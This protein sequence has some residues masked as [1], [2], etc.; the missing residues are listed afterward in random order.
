MKPPLVVFDCDGTLVDGQHSILSTMKQVFSANALAMPS[1]KEMRSTIGLS[2]VTAMATLHPD[3]DSGFHFD[4]SEQYK[5]VFGQYRMSPEFLHEPLYEGILQVLHDLEDAGYLLA[6]ATGKSMRGLMRVLGHHGLIDKFI[7]LQTAD[8]HPS[9]PHPSM[10]HSCIADAGSHAGQ[11]LV[12]G[13]TSYDMEMARAAKTTA[14]GV[15]WG[16]HDEDVLMAAGADHIVQDV[17]DLPA[18]VE[19][20]LMREVEA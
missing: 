13:D 17:A 20:L 18:L 8:T 4:L 10:V 14:I 12:I 15:K 9:K 19:N 3:G 2:L 7:S 5:T 11:T 1:D 6:V 16:Y